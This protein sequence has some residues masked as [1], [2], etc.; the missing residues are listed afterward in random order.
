MTSNPQRRGLPVAWDEARE[1]L[2]VVLLLS[3]VLHALAPIL[4]YGAIGGRQSW[5][6]D[7]Y[8]ALTNINAFTALLLLGAAVTICTTPAADVVPRL[9]QG[10]Y[11]VSTVVTV[12][13]LVAI[14]NVLTIPTAPDSALL[15]LS[16]VAWRPGPA[17][18]LA[19]TAAWM[20]RRGV[21]LG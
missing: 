4:R 3:A 13:G 14:V 19:G 2:A 21:L 20:S 9:R 5:W 7:L 11:W 12:M 16:I 8:G 18:V 10:V 1:I 15:R 17:V 6:E